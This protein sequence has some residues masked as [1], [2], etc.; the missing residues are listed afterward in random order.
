MRGYRR[1]DGRLGIRNV[2]AV[3]Y[4]VEC[5]RHVANQITQ[6][7]DHDSDV[8]LVG[9]PGCFRNDYAQ[10][11]LEAICTHP[12]VGA[13]LICS[14]G[15]EGFD[16][17]ALQNRIEETNRPVKT[18]VIQDVGGTGAAI[19]AG[20]EWVRDALADLAN[21]ETEPMSFGDLVIG[22]ICGG[23]DG[24]SGI[25]ANPAVGVAFDEL[26]DRGARVIFEETGE[27]MGCDALLE[28]RAADQD[29][30]DNI[31]AALDKAARHYADLGQPS[32]A[33]GNADG[34]LTTIEE[35][36]YGA[37]AKSGSRPIVGLLK[38]GIV[39]DRA[40]VYLLDVVP[41]GPTRWGFANIN[42]NAE[43]AELIACGAHLIL[44]TTGRGSVVGSAVSPVIKICANP[45]TYE[46]MPLDMDINGG[47]VLRGD[48]TVEQV[49][50]QILELIG[51]LGEGE[52]SVS[53]QLGH[54]EF[55]MTYKSF[56][57]VGPSCHPVG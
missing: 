7:F 19:E 9:F 30:K 27:L 21:I 23:S 39:V 54:R 2:T 48:A 40:G 50:H 5:A 43:V 51:R 29:V 25:T 26:V 55:I 28:A 46:R 13:V 18:I 22:T 24:T 41:D 6:Q 11:L 53:E 45:E 57:P 34:G 52:R 49:G 37:Y 47:A 10:K 15:C 20:Q 17:V 36:S 12:N 42:D 56:D 35:K 14:L 31:K 32:F 4:L 3:V 33:P 8:H 1:S 44:F 16:R 38:P